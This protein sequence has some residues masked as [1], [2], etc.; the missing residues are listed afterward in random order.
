MAKKQGI[1]LEGRE[2][3][4]GKDTYK[5]GDM[6]GKPLFSHICEC[7]VYK[8]GVEYKWVRLEKIIEMFNI[9]I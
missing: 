2:F 5:I 7:R 8:N 9:K 3:K 6:R 1:S 4:W